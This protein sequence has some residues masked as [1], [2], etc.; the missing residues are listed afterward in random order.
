MSTRETYQVEFSGVQVLADG[1]GFLLEC[2]DGQPQPL[3]LQF[4][5]WALYQLMRTFPRIEAAM[6]HAQTN[7]S[8]AIMAHPVVGWSVERSGLD[9]DIALCVQTDQQIESAFTFDIESAKA[10][11][12]A[13]DEAIERAA[14]S[15]AISGAA[16]NAN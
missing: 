10:F 3:R 9:R 5:A 13:L 6:E 8:S 2:R 12:L 11:R 7:L 1:E 4:P 14:R 16:L 15:P